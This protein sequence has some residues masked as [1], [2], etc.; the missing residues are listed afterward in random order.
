MKG[1]SMKRSSL[2]GKGSKETT[3]RKDCCQTCPRANQGHPCGAYDF[4]H[5]DEF[6]QR[7]RKESKG[8]PPEKR[9]A[10]FS[11]RLS[12][13]SC[14]GGMLFLCKKC[15]LPDKT[16]SYPQREKALCDVCMKSERERVKKAKEERV[17]QENVE[18]LRKTWDKVVGGS[19]NPF[20]K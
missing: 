10:Y 16:Y 20:R 12:D 14:D 17:R 7:I 5:I 13:S 18:V 9:L 3:E 4:C 15:S 2:T 1:T 11:K 19:Y 8:L 6:I